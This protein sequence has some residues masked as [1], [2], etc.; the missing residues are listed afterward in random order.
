MRC[1]Q[2]LPFLGTSTHR[3][4]RTMGVRKTLRGHLQSAGR[5]RIDS[6][7]PSPRAQLE[8]CSVVERHCDQLQNKGS[9]SCLVA[10]GR[11]SRADRE[12]SGRDIPHRKDWRNGEIAKN[13]VKVREGGP[14][15][16][17]RV[18]QGLQKQG[19]GAGPDA[20]APSQAPALLPH[21]LQCFHSQEKPHLQPSSAAQGHLGTTLLHPKFPTACVQGTMPADTQLCAQLPLFQ[22]C[23]FSPKIHPSFCAHLRNLDQ[24]L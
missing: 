14:N 21:L 12:T 24:D 16:E 17:C 13:E 5:H 19:A 4:H 2:V 10:E 1:L 3:N 15:T 20:W 11:G 7:L 9:K 6:V 18:I 22:E 23:D 8:R